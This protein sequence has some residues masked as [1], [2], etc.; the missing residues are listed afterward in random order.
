MTTQELQE[1]SKKV[2]EKF[3]PY[4]DKEPFYI[5]TNHHG[6]DLDPFWLHQDLATVMRLAIEHDI[7]ISTDS[8]QAMTAFRKENG[9]VTTINYPIKSFESKEQA[10]IVAVMKALCEVSE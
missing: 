6:I 10:V 5:D 7:A 9:G 2:A 3:E 1:L 8:E 4:Y